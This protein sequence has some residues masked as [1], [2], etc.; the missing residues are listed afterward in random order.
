MSAYRQYT[1]PVQYT[2][3]LHLQLLSFYD[4]SLI[5]ASIKA[6]SNM[7]SL[8][9]S[10]RYICKPSPST[11][12]LNY[13]LE[14][15]SIGSWKLDRIIYEKDLVMDTV[16]WTACEFGMNSGCRKKLALTVQPEGKPTLG[17]MLSPVMS[18]GDDSDL[19]PRVVYY[20]FH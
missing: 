4:N 3:S 18:D 9:K 7:Q 17:G 1:I 14:S 6:K 20:T 13:S 16:H 5:F 10:R 8:C 2:S 15:F 11:S 19:A 12:F